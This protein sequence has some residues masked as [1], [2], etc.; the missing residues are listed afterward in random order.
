[1]RSMLAKGRSGKAKR[2]GKAYSTV[3]PLDS[4]YCFN[5]K[6]TA[7]GHLPTHVHKEMEQHM[8]EYAHEVES[9]MQRKDEEERDA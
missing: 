2:T 7:Q 8:E 5:F 4:L 9:E 3:I 6:L 1:M